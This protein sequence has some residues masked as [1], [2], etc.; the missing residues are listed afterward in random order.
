MATKSEQHH[1]EEQRTGR[2]KAP[3]KRVSRSKPGSPAAKRRPTTKRGAGKAT[4]A[5]EPTRAGRPSRKSTRKSANRVKADSNLTLRED[6]QKGSPESRFEKAR[7]QRTRPR[8][9]A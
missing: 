7:V 9:S 8:G 3:K 4:Y 5:I 1:A 2:A 6:R